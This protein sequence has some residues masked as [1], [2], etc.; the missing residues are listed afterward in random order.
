MTA[1]TTSPIL[2]WV[3][4]SPLWPAAGT[5]GTKLRQPALLSFTSDKFTDELSA[6]VSSDPVDLPVARWESNRLP[7]PGTKDPSAWQPS[8]NGLPLKLFQPV[9][10]RYYMVAASL[11]CRQVGMP[12]H[13]LKV[14]NQERTYFVLRKLDTDGA[15]MA[16]VRDPNAPSDPTKYVWQRQPDQSTRAQL[17]TN[18]ELYPLFPVFIPKTATRAARRLHAGV[19]PTAS[20]D[21]TPPAPSAS[22][23]AGYD[24]A[25]EA[26][27][28]VVGAYDGILN[29]VASLLA[30]YAVTNV[31]G[32]P[33][34]VKQDPGMPVLLA[35]ATAALM[36]DLADILQKY[37]PDVFACI[38]NSPPAG[39]PTASASLALY[40]ALNEALVDHTTS[41]PT[42]WLSALTTAWASMTAINTVPS[43]PT[44]AVLPFNLWNEVT[45]DDSPP[46]T[47]TG[48][49]ASQTLSEL[50]DAA[51]AG[52]SPVP[53]ADPID[54]A[55]AIPIV[56]KL[57]GK[58]Q[59]VVRCVFQRC[60][61]K[62][63]QYGVF[64]PSLLSAPSRPFEIA[65][66]FDSDAPARNIVIPMPTDTSPSGLRKF[67]K[68][69]GFLL[70]PSLQQQLCQVQ[71]FASVLK[72]QLST[73]PPA[74]SGQFC[75]F[76]I[77]IITII[78]MMLMMVMAIVLN[79]VFWWLPFLKIC[80][81]LPFGSSSE[82]EES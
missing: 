59:Y 25:A 16:W 82:P 50:L 28:R 40:D 39:P 9:H 11:V 36:V 63:A 68:S 13:A 72:G 29:T 62:R 43:P 75:S 21:T 23:K 22:Q 32:L 17:A 2:Q 65:P 20:R 78:A 53:T 4:P 73:C 46:N 7:P 10:G 47:P 80:L 51:I 3:S 69:V 61:F 37:V 26:E 48:P 44:S 66:F 35:D 54:K 74:P 19:I 60:A 27:Q 38:A 57:D 64:F 12:D 42:T 52:Q 58:A 24:P 8:Q 49:I 41:P 77:P 6:A 45:V 56:P 79:I 81:P 1:A 18:E 31:A 34:A 30:T 76:S 67:P 33:D 55:A 70:S 71:D 15:E 5:D 14:A